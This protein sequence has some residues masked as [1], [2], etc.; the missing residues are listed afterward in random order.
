MMTMTMTMTMTMEAK[1]GGSKKTTHSR[2]H[3]LLSFL[4]PL[5]CFVNGGRL[6]VRREKTTEE[7]G[8]ERTGQ[9]D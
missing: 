5:L 8:E 3:P 9:N 1:H 7:G 4:L 6:W 2:S